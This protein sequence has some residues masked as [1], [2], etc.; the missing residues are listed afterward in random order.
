MTAPISDML[1]TT[2]TSAAQQLSEKPERMDSAL[3]Q[4]APADTAPSEAI[5]MKLV[6]RIHEALRLYGVE[7]EL[8]EANSRVVTRIIDKEN[9][10]LIRQIPAEAVLRIAEHLPEFQG[11][12][13]D[14]KA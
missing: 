3:S 9:G 4:L 12:L 1:A 7:F 11:L 6:E 10:E 13:L 2:H 14:Q 8:G 5:G